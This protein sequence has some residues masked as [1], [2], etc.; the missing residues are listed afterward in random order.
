MLDFSWVLAGPYATRILADH[1]ADVIKVQTA[2]KLV[3]YVS[4]GY[5]ATW[6]RNKRSIT[7]NLS[8]RAARTLVYDLVKLADVVVENFS[9]A[10]A[11]PVGPR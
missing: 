8:H 1:G 7:L 2:G 9:R 4:D 5:F 10:R 3:G 11:P 6:N